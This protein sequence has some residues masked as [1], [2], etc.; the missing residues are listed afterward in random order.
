MIIIP[1]AVIQSP[2]F[3]DARRLKWFLDLVLMAGPD[4]VV[5]GT[6]REIAGRLGIAKSSL[7]DYLGELRKY[8]MVGC[9]TR[10]EKPTSLGQNLGQKFSGITI[11]NIESYLGGKNR[12]SDKFSDVREAVSPVPPSNVPPYNPSLNNPLYPPSQDYPT[13]GSVKEDVSQSQEART[14]A[15]ARI[16]WRYPSSV[17]RS[18]LGFDP[19]RIA[20]WKRDRMEAELRA[21]APEIGMEERM[22][23]AFMRKWGENTGELLR[24]EYEPTFVLRTRA[25]GFVEA[26]QARESKKK[27]ATEER[28]DGYDRFFSKFNGNGTDDYQVDEQRDDA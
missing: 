18:A 19:E 9:P 1:D 8:G 3:K 7:S 24:A 17:V 21:M 15:R 20:G 2:I 23:V 26:W 27:T 14:H 4:G 28:L 5:P 6:V 13:S 12:V 11:C 16:D 25:E 10:T 22:I